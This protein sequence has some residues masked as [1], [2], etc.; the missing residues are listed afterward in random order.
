MR[1]SALHYFVREEPTRF[2]CPI[3]T[4][5]ACRRVPHRVG[6]TTHD[7]AKVTCQ[8]CMKSR[9]FRE[10]TKQITAFGEKLTIGC[11]GQ[12]AKAWG[13]NTRPRQQLSKD[14]ND[15]AFLADCELGEA[16]ENPG[17]YEG[18][19]AKPMTSVEQLNKWCFRECERCAS[20]AGE[21]PLKLP[22]LRARLYNIPARAP[23]NNPGLL[24]VEFVVVVGYPR[25]VFA[26]QY[27]KGPSD[28]KHV[29]RHGY[30]FTRESVE[31]WPFKTERAA[32]AKARILARH[33]GWSEHE[34]ITKPLPQPTTPTRT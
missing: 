23:A 11:D 13:I 33:M 1:K 10:Q 28:P 29:N 6:N 5:P 26:G 8:H 20:S 12:C 18:G 21:K 2:D 14:P 25:N 34:M 16:P 15:Y 32:Q 19:H 3:Y 17:T 9:K 7:R 31:A 30:G 27:L 22:N 24:P 4:G